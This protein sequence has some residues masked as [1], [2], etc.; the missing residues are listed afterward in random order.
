MTDEDQGTNISVNSRVAISKTLEGWSI[1]VGSSVCSMNEL[2]S[3]AKQ[4]KREFID[5]VK[6]NKKKNLL[7][8]G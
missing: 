8:V 4:L 5:N 2:K 3:F 7:G 1:D 6:I